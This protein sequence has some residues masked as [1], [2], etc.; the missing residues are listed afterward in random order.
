MKRLYLTLVLFVSSLTVFAALP[1]I[2]G[3]LALCL[4]NSSVLSNPVT[5]GT[6]TSGTTG[7]ATIGSSSGLVIGVTAGTADITYT[8]GVDFAYA[9]VTINPL[10]SPITGT[11]AVC[12]GSTTTLSS[13]SPGGV[14][15]SSVLSV[16]VIGTGSGVVT[17]IAAGTTLIT[18]VLPTSCA[19]TRVVTVYPT[20]SIFAGLPLCAGTTTLYSG[21]PAG[22]VWSSSAAGILTVSPTAL[23]TGVAPG[24]A[25]VT[26]TLTSGCFATTPVTV[27]AAIGTIGG[28]ASVCVGLTTTLTHPAT[29]GT[30]SSSAPAIAW[31][32]PTTGVVTGASVGTTTVSYSVP[33]GCFSTVV[34]TVNS[35]PT[36]LTGTASLCAGSTTTLSSTAGVG[37]TWSSSATAVATVGTS[38]VVYGAGTGTAT[39]YYSL[40]VCG[41]VSRDVTVNSTC[42]GTPVPGGITASASTVCSGTP[43]TLNLP[44]YTYSCGHLIQW[45][46]SPDGFSWSDLAGGLSVP[47]VFNPTGNYFYRCRITCSSTGIAAFSGP[48]FVNVNFA[49]GSH[50]VI[51]TPSTFCVPSHFYVEACGVSSTFSVITSFG[52]GTSDTTAMTTTGVSNAHIYH[53][54]GM[55]GT[56]SVQH[57]MLNGTTPMDT[58]V[59]SYNYQFCRTLNISFYKD[60]NSNCIYDLGDIN[61]L[62]PINTRID[63]NG[64]PIDTISATSG[65]YYKAYGTT[66][67]IYAFRPLSMAGGMLVSC[68]S[69]GVLYDT[70]GTFA[71]TYGTK[72]FG[73]TCSPSLTHDLKVNVTTLT[74]PTQQRLT[75]LVTNLNCTVVTPTVTLAFS[76]KFGYYSTLY[77]CTA[78]NPAPTTASGTTLTWTLPAMAPD[79]TRTI[80]VFLAR[81]SSLGSPLA[82]G[83][84]VNETVTV[85]PIT[86]DANPSNN[87]RIKC[88]TV[89]GAYDPNDIAV[90]PE[91]YI[92]PCTQLQYRVRFEN[93]GNDTAHNVYV[94]DTLSDNLDP[95]TLEIE[96]SSHAMNVTV[97]NDG[98]RNIA[99]FDFPN[100]KL[101]DSAHH[102]LNDGMFLFNIK[103]RSTLADGDMIPNRVGIYFDYNPVVMTNTV[104]NIIGIAPILGPN[105][106]C[107]GYPDTMLNTTEGGIWASSVPATGTVSSIGIVTGITSGTTVISYTVTNAC[108]S[109][110]ATKA[111]SVNP[112]VVPGIA[113]TTGTPD[114]ICSGSPVTFTASPVYG[115]LSPT[116]IWRVNGTVTGGGIAYTYT[117]VIGDTVTVL[118][119]SS[120]ACTLPPTAADTVALTVINMAM[121]VASISVSPN[122]TSCAGSPVSYTITPAFGGA[123]PGFNWFVNG[124]PVGTGS[125]YMYTPATGDVVFCRMG[126]NFMCRLADTVNSSTVNMTVDPLYIPVISVAATPGLIVSP[127]ELLTL[128]ATVTGAGPT[129]VYKWDV[130]GVVVV[131]ATTNVFTSATLADYDSVTCTVTGSGVCNI[132]AYNSVFV[133]V[134]PAGVRNV[135]AGGNLHVFPNPN[136]GGF[137]LR[138]VVA[139]RSLSEAAVSISNM[140]GQNVYSGTI[141]VKGGSMD[142]SIQLPAGLPNGM[143]LLN[144]QAGS[145]NSVLRFVVER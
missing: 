25:N 35:T 28:T 70:I 104:T 97:L 130:N 67:T 36:P 50:S 137:R 11:S 45:Q 12:D 16:A 79:A 51:S 24:V 21:S 43:V 57:I 59:F 31:V 6:W 85:D 14:W 134:W 88:D 74:N 17:G 15:S 73:L 98:V 81:P 120:Q 119:T 106:I 18:Y 13:V 118:M 54:Y 19:T 34:V 48:V 9:I 124:L 111:V 7:V 64:I 29:G 139:D 5:G 4:G 42:S 117:P 108:T 75:I 86:G 69:G 83:D 63:S 109:R 132:T 131:G 40:G 115:G 101:L 58:V 82:L 95:A 145:E 114:T 23:L 56:Y 126:S 141:G 110:T 100:I 105:D 142:V 1:P 53:T 140:L 66:G 22:G 49:I 133:T 138:G 41:T 2:T 135:A 60:N 46:Y 125:T 89:I 123:L 96:A 112:I 129:P 10:P 47:Y 65:F 128:T 39:I 99:K 26:F 77:P 76:P 127:G 107:L 68:P 102:G 38:G 84:T 78:T 93:T 90:S 116:I 27:N 61:N 32:A 62:I 113:V 103:A 55:P 20:P 80:T 30:W 71:N 91:G 122:D 8:D 33:S 94:L 72:K 52:D 121:P 136:N 144:M 44:S 37:G 143:Y 3:T 87:I 92:L